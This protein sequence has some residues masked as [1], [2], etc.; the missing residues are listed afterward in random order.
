MLVVVME[1]MYDE[2]CVVFHPQTVFYYVVK[3]FWLAY[4]LFLWKNRCHREAESNFSKSFLITMICS[5][6][7]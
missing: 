4:L 5:K 3:E 7:S 1:K 2:D 6:V